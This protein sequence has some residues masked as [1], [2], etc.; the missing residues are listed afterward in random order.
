MTKSKTGPVDQLKIPRTSTIP[1]L[2]TTFP[3]ISLLR[4]RFHCYLYSAGQSGVRNTIHQAPHTTTRQTSSL[5]RPHPL[6]TPSLA[7]HIVTHH[8]HRHSPH[9]SSLTTHSPSQH[10]H[11]PN[12]ITH[13]TLPLST[14]CRSPHIATLHTSSPSKH[15]RRTSTSTAHDH[16]PPTTHNPPRS[17]APEHGLCQSCLG[18]SRTKCSRWGRPVLVNAEAGVAPRGLRAEALPT[19]AGVAP[20]GLRAG[21]LPSAAGVALPAAAPR[22]PRVVTPRAVAPRRLGHPEA[23]H[24]QGSLRTICTAAGHTTICRA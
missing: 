1:L 2:V 14:H 22:G 10:H 16:P 21:P 17:I 6:T 7:T 5:T 15:R 13:H 4:C 8:T 9:T 12:I 20:R 3:N 19:A 11:A 18:T 23:T 24:T